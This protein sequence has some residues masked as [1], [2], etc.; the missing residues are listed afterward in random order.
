[1]E[2]K[3]PLVKKTVLTKLK[4]SSKKT[5][6]I[7]ALTYFLNLAT[8]LYKISALLCINKTVRNGY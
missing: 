2:N 3:V 7:I 4:I 8:R 6:G 1:M 5:L